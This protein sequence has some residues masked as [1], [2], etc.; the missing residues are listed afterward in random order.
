MV[1][2]MELVQGGSLDCERAG[3]VIY[4]SMEGN[5]GLGQSCKEANVDYTSTQDGSWVKSEFGE[6]NFATGQP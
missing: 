1:N 6:V 2:Y 4:C 5:F 3:V